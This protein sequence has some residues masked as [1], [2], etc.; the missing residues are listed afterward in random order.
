MIPPIALREPVGPP[1]APLLLLGP[2]LGTSTVLWDEAAVSLRAHFR[3]AAWDLPGHGRADAASEPF[4]VGELAD[5]VVEAVDGF[6]EEHVLYAGVSLG[7][8]VGLELALR[9]GERLLAL[10]VVCSGASIGTPSSWRERAER[11]LRVGTASLVVESATRWFAPTTLARSPSIASTLLESLADV[12]DES[13]SRCC[14]ALADYDIHDRLAELQLP[15]QAIWADQD[16]VTP[17]SSSREIVDGVARGE[18]A[19][20]QNAGHLAP[21]ERPEEI[22]ELL[23][24]FFAAR[25]VAA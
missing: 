19:A 9:H 4:V 12:D 8:A 3:V 17:E 20:V 25:A 21:A 2:S 15:V 1:G 14:E 5:A 6:G 13:Y 24:S 22:A 18:L 16:V 7:G 11:V 10:A 23:R